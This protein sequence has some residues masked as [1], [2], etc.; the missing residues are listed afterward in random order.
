MTCPG[1][2]QPQTGRSTI[3]WQ[4]WGQSLACRGCEDWS[5]LCARDMYAI[6]E[7]ATRRNKTGRF[8]TATQTNCCNV[9]DLDR[10]QD[11]SMISAPRMAAYQA[12]AA[13]VQLRKPLDTA[14]T[15]STRLCLID[16][17]SDY[18]HDV[19]G[20]R[21][22]LERSHYT[23]NH[24]N[25]GRGTTRPTATH[26]A[27]LSKRHSRTPFPTQQFRIPSSWPFA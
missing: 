25:L 21:V 20:K 19:I 23:Q 17:L 24:R 13:W 3:Y 8:P 12:A 5:L 18:E 22:L 11:S 14:T 4:Y 9:G 10:T 27:I 1:C 2:S 6:R 7:S 15:L 16:C 26:G